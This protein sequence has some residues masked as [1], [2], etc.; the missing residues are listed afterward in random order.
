MKKRKNAIL[1]PVGLILIFVGS[2]LLITTLDLTNLRPNDLT[3]S[4]PLG[5]LKI[6]SLSTDQEGQ[7]FVGFIFLSSGV[8]TEIAYSRIKK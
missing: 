8:A 5:D 3:Y 2:L 7:I 1:V 4:G 6:D